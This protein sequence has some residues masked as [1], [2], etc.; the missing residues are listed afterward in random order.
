MKED[1][2][3]GNHLG[4]YGNFS[5]ATGEPSVTENGPQGQQAPE[6]PFPLDT[7]FINANRELLPF[8]LFYSSKL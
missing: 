3:Y 2:F 7:D 1:V 4:T 8:H 5:D 6:H